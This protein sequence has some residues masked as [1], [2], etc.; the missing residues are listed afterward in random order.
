MR[1]RTDRRP[2]ITVSLNPVEVV[3]SSTAA[4]GAS[5]GLTVE[6]PAGSTMMVDGKLWAQDDFGVWT[7]LRTTERP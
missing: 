5:F 6:I 2:T 3:F 1:R 7:V 4:L